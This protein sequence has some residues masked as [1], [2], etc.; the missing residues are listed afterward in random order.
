M[1]IFYCPTA[2]PGSP[3]TMD[4]VESKHITGVLRK[5]QGEEIAVFDGMGNLYSATIVGVGKKALDIHV[6]ELRATSPQG[7]AQLHVAIAPPKNIERFEW[8]VEKAT[9]IG[10]STITPIICKHSERRE[11]RNDRIE[12]VIL[13]AC[14]QSMKYRLPQLDEI[15]KFET[16]INKTESAQK[17]IGYCDEKNLLLQSEYKPAG[18]MLILI[19]PE[20]DF[21]AEE[22]AL[23]Q[24]AGY[25]P[26]SLGQSRLRLETAGVVATTIFNVINNY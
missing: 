5:A 21:T 11:L 24:Q 10:I 22:V 7:H 1:N 8:F 15:I 19:G 14:K 20:G 13:S 2:L 3:T 17:F 9:E 4:E 18:D 6:N 26:I 16:F 23:A 12:K 25:K